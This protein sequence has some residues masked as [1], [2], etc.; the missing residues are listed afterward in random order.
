MYPLKVLATKSDSRVLPLLHA[1]RPGEIDGCLRRR[2]EDRPVHFLFVGDSQ[3]RMLEFEFRRWASRGVDI[4][5]YDSIMGMDVNRTG[6]SAQNVDVTQ[7]VNGCAHD[8]HSKEEV[9]G[10]VLA[11]V[12]AMPPRARLV[13]VAGYGIWDVVFS[14][15]SEKTTLLRM[16][17]EYAA[18][19]DAVVT[20]VLVA[21]APRNIST[22]FYVRNMFVSYK[23]NGKEFVPYVF[24][25]NDIV[26]RAF[27]SQRLKHANNAAISFRFLDVYR[28]SALRRHEMPYNSDGLH[29]ACIGRLGYQLCHHGLRAPKRPD[30]VAWAVMQLILLNFCGLFQL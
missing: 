29:W 7:V 20:S 15:C 2:A 17:R 4:P 21:G 22:D 26:G 18:M 16:E 6:W 23:L 27:S 10:K 30:E 12:S 28:F 25:V 19:L 9:S 11:A 1:A 13:V 24:R 5:R 14:N 3:T 8:I